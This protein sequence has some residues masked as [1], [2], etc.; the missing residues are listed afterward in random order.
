MSVQLQFIQ[1]ISITGHSLLAEISPE[2]V[3]LP[4]ELVKMLGVK[5][6]NGF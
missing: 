4:D 1:N 3:M 2:F 6:K 5:D